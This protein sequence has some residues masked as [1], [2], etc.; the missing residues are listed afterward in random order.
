[1]DVEHDGVDDEVLPA[2]THRKAGLCQ[3]GQSQHEGK[4]THLAGSGVYVQDLVPNPMASSL[5]AL[6]AIFFFIYIYAI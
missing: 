2:T 1:M 6:L 3:E 5:I 4:Q